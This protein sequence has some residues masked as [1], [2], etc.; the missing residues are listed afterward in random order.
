MILVLSL[1]CTTPSNSAE[2]DSRENPSSEKYPEVISYFE[3]LS[4][5]KALVGKRVQFIGYLIS[6]EYEE[7]AAL[8]PDQDR[9][10]IGEAATR[11]AAFS[12]SEN[13]TSAL[14]DD[15]QAYVYLEG[16]I[17]LGGEGVCDIDYIIKYALS[18]YPAGKV[19][20][21]EPG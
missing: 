21:C 3:V 1:G 13:C 15:F 18:A 4:L 2:A 14:G 16:T 8:Y 12:T 20:I 11:L 9:A 6:N 10:I 17:C 19:T 5:K 7:G